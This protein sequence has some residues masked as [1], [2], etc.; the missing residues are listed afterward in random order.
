MPSPKQQDQAGTRAKLLNVAGELFAA[1]GFAAVTVREICA[2]ANTNVASVNYHFGDK[3]G[4]YNAVILSIVQ[5]AEEAGRSP[6]RGTPEEQLHEFL[7]RYLRGLLGS[8]KPNWGFRVIQREMQSPTP[9]LKHIV[10]TVVKPTEAR[11]KEIIG[12]IVRRNPNDE[13]VRLCAHSIIGQCLHYKNAAPV[14]AH[15]WPELWEDPERIDKV[16]NHI[17]A[18][19][20]CALREL[21]RPKK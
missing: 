14:L 18:F 6:R 7:S 5:F 12:Q 13:S 20:Q 3:L 17:A 1:K 10:E 4:L 16:V 8:G 21:A 11:L 9:V 19:S 2:Q 15:L